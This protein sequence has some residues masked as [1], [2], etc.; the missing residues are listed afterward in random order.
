[1]HMHVTCARAA[2]LPM[3]LALVVAHEVAYASSTTAVGF[4]AAA[5]HRQRRRDILKA[6]PEVRDLMESDFWVAWLGLAIVPLFGLAVWHAPAASP[7]ELV[8]EAYTIGSL[9]ANWAVYCSHALSHGRW[10]ALVRL[11]HTHRGNSL[12][13]RK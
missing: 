1:M 11:G 10:R 5:W 13:A 6:H 8:I 9:R 3:A 4:D 2:P 12:P 7:I